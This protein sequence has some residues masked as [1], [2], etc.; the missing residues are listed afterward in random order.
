[1]GTRRGDGE[2]GREIVTEEIDEASDDKGKADGAETPVIRGAEDIDN[3][4]DEGGE[5]D[6]EE[7]SLPNVPI[8]LFVDASSHFINS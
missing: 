3:T 7:P 2:I 6:H 5:E 4:D 1:M 8:Y